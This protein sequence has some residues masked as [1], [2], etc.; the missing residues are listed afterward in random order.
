MK[1]PLSGMTVWVICVSL[2]L[3]GGEAFG[4]RCGTNLISEGD[5]KARVMAECGEPANIEMWEEVRIRRDFYR[6]LFPERERD[7]YREPLLIKE[8]I[9]VE[10]WTYNRGPNR[11]MRHLIFENGRLREIITGPY[12]F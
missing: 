9:T 5:L 10:E 8:Y 2:A 11:F 1:N 12:G 6:P 3:A 7:R 4:F